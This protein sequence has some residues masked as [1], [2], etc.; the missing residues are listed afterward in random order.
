MTRRYGGTGLGLAISRQLAVMMGG[1]MWAESEGIE[2]KGSTFHFTIQTRA[3]PAPP[4]RYLYETQPDLSGKRVL[5]VDDN[6][7]NRQILTLQTQAWGMLPR[8]AASSHEALDWVRQGTPFDVALLDMHMVDPF[9]GHPER[10]QD[11]LALA[12]ALQQEL[13]ASR[14]S[15][16]PF[17]VV[18][19][20]SG[21]RDGAAEG[22]EFAA[23]LTKPIK[24]SQLY[25]VLVQIFARE[26]HKVPQRELATD[27]Q[28]D[29][30]MGQRLPLRILVAEDNLINQQ[31]ALSFLERLG[32]RADVAANGL[33]VLLSLRRQ[34]YDAVLMD[35]QMPEMDGLEA[36]RRIRQ[37]AP[38]ELAAE[39][40]PRIIA[41][42]ANAMRE[43]CDVCLE[44]GMDDYV[45]KPIQVGELIRA[46]SKCRPRPPST[47]QQPPQVMD[48]PV[49]E[50]EVLDPKAMNR[51][52]ATLGAQA[53]RMLPDLIKD[54]Y[55]DADRLLHQAR[56]ALEQG[57]TNRLR[58]A[59][60]SLKSTSATLGAM[61]LSAVAR[62]LEQSAREG[63]LEGAEGQIA[64]AEAEL[65]RARTVL[66]AVRHEP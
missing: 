32:Y 4:R 8:A 27:S 34:P 15:G 1:R 36:T 62:E 18:M 41:M 50:P 38:S 26:P 14:E 45:A 54:F 31:V 56:Q 44:A 47:T 3:A 24:A 59:A 9:P 60:H 30:Q 66:E 33:E 22:V 17:P 48:S 2:G 43:D 63:R 6:A 42:T 21:H 28:F 49:V 10:R 57:Q 61:A 40:Q 25:D 37:L 19:L 55:K 29:A 16:D 13:S 39:M 7:T 58:R 52:R 46:L 20:T 53:D 11:G 35:V 5:I 64:Q 65:T 12:V 51:L 23:F